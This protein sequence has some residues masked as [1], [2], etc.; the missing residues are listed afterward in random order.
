R[1]AG[2]GGFGVVYRAFHLGFDSPIAITVLRLPDHWS[3]EKKSRRI[4]AFQREGKVLFN[5]SKLHSSIVRAFETGAVMLSDGALAPYLALEWL[6]GLPLSQ[7]SSHRRKHGL[8]AMA[9]DEVLQLLAAPAA[10]LAR[11]HGKGIVHRDVKPAN[12]F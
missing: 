12:L 6:D 5:L 10:A 9:L 3:S 8:P 4:D 2:A 11:A 7:E 1:L